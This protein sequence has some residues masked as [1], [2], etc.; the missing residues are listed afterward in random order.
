MGTSET[1]FV[2][3]GRVYITQPMANAGL[4]FVVMP[5]PADSAAEN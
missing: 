2:F 3:E 5:E 1:S 4:L